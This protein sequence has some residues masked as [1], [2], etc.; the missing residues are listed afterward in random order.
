[1]SWEDILKLI[2]VI[3]SGMATALPLA[4]KLAQYV[5]TAVKEKNWTRLLSLVL[6]LMSKAEG[7]FASG[8][9]RKAWVMASVEELAG[10]VDYQIDQE[11]LSELIDSLC[12]MSKNVNRK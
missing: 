3:L 6:G 4:I 1:M 7:M 11:S 8:E 10:T 2:G 5:Q 12:A 9:E